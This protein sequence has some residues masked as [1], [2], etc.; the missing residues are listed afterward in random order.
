MESELGLSPRSKSGIETRSEEKALQRFRKGDQIIP[1]L[2]GAL[3]ID[4]SES[5]RLLLLGV[6]LDWCSYIFR[7]KAAIERVG[8]WTGA[9]TKL[10]WPDR[11]LRSHWRNFAAWKQISFVG[12]KTQL[13]IL[14]LRAETNTWT[15]SPQSTVSLNE[16]ISA[17][18]PSE[19]S[20][21]VE[22]LFFAHLHS[23]AGLSNKRNFI[24]L[25]KIE[26]QRVN[27]NPI[28]GRQTDTTKKHASNTTLL[29]SRFHEMRERNR[30]WRCCREPLLPRIYFT[31][32]HRAH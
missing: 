19:D 5:D 21:Y 16:K 18:N 26:I 17:T 7:N 20:V 30:K 3:Q 24:Q 25:S 32:A 23:K 13:C 6:I 15:L 28:V 12:L 11:V 4:F 22:E 27:G 29:H 8:T 31:T 9:D 10:G 14:L 2:Y 1:K